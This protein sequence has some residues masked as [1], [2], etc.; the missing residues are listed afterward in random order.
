MYAVHAAAAVTAAMAAS[1]EDSCTI[2]RPRDARLATRRR[3]RS[4]PRVRRNA[5]VLVSELCGSF[6]TRTW[7]FPDCCEVDR[8]RT[9][10][11]RAPSREITRIPRDLP[12]RS[13]GG[14]PR[15][16]TLHTVL[17]TVGIHRIV[18]IHWRV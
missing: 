12:A 10:L 17:I 2:A 11:L 1:L 8:A 7:P 18:N 14:P 13:A 4:A 15:T 9:D 5:L 6:A 16:Y 3:P